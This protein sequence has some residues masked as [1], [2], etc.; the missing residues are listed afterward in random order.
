MLTDVTQI[1]SATFNIVAVDP[2]LMCGLSVISAKVAE[3]GDAFA[4][5]H[6]SSERPWV[7]AVEYVERWCRSDAE[8][9]ANLT[10][11]AE[12][13]DSMPGRRILTAQPEAQQAIGGLIYVTTQCQTTFL[14]QPRA[15]VKRVVTDR[16]LRH[17]GWYRKTKD[18]HA[19]DATRHACFRILQSHPEL[20]H[21]LTAGL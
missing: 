2:G 19:N 7:N 9:R 15:E 18:G 10:V 1:K 12:R 14:Q 8:I 13:Y 5:N 21:R 4:I 6:S 11:V 3:D 20:W 16:V 17:L